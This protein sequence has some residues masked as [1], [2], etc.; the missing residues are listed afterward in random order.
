MG[1]LGRMEYSS[2]SKILYEYQLKGKE[3]CDVHRYD[4]QF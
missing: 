2:I 1:H 3:V 4:E